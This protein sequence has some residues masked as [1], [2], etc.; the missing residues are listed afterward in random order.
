MTDE[1]RLLKH[2]DGHQV[3]EFKSNLS[4]SMLGANLLGVV[5][6]AAMMGWALA[7][8][9]P[10]M[11]ERITAKLSPIIERVAKLE[12]RLENVEAKIK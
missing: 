10:E 6:I 12:Q 2:C 1:K 3:I 11:E 4:M 9:I 8:S 7:K 5:V